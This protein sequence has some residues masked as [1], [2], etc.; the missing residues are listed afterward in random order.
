MK[1]LKKFTEHEF[2]LWKMNASHPFSQLQLI[3]SIRSFLLLFILP[4]LIWGNR[5]HALLCL[6]HNQQAVSHYAQCFISLLCPRHISYEFSF[7]RLRNVISQRA[8]HST[9]HAPKLCSLIHERKAQSQGKQT[10]DSIS[11]T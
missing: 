7:M 1:W 4:R 5:A 6:C 9:T 2:F 3:R 8:T 11:F 10:N